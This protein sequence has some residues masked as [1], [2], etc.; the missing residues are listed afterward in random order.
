MAATNTQLTSTASEYGS[1]IDVAVAALSDYGSEIGI[2]DLD[3]DTLLAGAF[4]SIAASRP[5]E[6]GVVLPSIESEEGEREDEEEDVDGFVQVHQP[7]RLRIARHR[8]GGTNIGFQRTAQ[9]IQSSPLR[10][11]T[12]LEVEYDERS[13][14][15]WSGMCMQ[16]QHYGTFETRTDG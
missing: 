2:E 6:R 8:N 14:R 7:S 1:D 13:R 12:A 9:D 15:A 11:P 3:E 10:E 4:E 5:A 16:H